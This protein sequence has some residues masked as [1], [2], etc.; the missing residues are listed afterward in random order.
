MKSISKIPLKK[1]DIQYETYDFTVNLDNDFGLVQQ[2]IRSSRSSRVISFA[3]LQT[4]NVS[5]IFFVLTIVE[6]CT[7][8]YYNGNNSLM[9]C[10]FT[11]VILKSFHNV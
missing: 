7:V 10:Y 8:R 1:R 2:C 3:I 6:Y 4:V 11:S 9:L 5:L